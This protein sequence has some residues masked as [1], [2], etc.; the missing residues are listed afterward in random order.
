MSSDPP[1]EELSSHP[2]DPES[3]AK[4]T[5]RSI[6]S[7]GIVLGVLHALGQG[8]GEFIEF[9]LDMSFVVSNLYMNYRFP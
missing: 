5:F 8:P 1:H 4:E 3:S 7:P 6:K 2:V 9:G